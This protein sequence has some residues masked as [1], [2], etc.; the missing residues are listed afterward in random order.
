MSFSGEL[1]LNAEVMMH[2]S[3]RR[4]PDCGRSGALQKAAVCREGEGVENEDEG[5]M[6]NR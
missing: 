2:S 6:N 3:N 5:Y 1:L 4:G